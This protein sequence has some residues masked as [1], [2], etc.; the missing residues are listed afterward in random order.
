VLTVEPSQ[1]EGFVCTEET[2]VRQYRRHSTGKAKDQMFW[3]YLQQWKK[4]LHDAA[5]LCAWT[6]KITSSLF[7][8]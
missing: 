3:H 8:Q 6:G 1:K 5:H 7:R 4:R 2:S